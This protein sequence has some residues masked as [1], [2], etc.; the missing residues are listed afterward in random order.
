M[1]EVPGWGAFQ[2]F[3]EHGHSCPLGCQNQIP[4]GQECPRSES[5]NHGP[6]KNLNGRITEALT[7]QFP[8]KASNLTDKA[9]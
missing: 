9:D 7:P 6:L 3:S 5:F 4:G 8:L 1:S 2:I